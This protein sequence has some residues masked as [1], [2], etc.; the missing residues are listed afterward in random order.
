MHAMIRDMSGKPAQAAPTRGGLLG[1]LPYLLDLIVPIV[2]FYALSK[3]GVSDFW[4]L[5]AGGVLTLVVTAVNTFR[6]GKLDSLGLLVV[7]ELALSVVLTFAVHNARLVLARPSLYIAVAAGWILW[8]SFSGRPV[9]VDTSKPMAL[10]G[11]GPQ[12]AVAYEWCVENSPEFLRIH[13]IVSGIWFAVFLA[14]AV[15][16]LV[17]IYS[18]HDLK[19][20]VWLTEVPGIIGIVLC[21]VASA[22]A[23]N[24]LEKIVDAQQAQMFPATSTKASE[25]GNEPVG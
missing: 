22:R 2:V 8:K 16:R 6:H 21:M 5:T 9:T 25:L 7:L 11:A 4:A 3:A 20:S 14:Y 13:R 18:V 12:R 15:L 1:V 23:G 24:K 19:E 17:I 10:K